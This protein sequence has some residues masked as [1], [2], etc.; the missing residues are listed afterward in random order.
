MRISTC[1]LSAALALTVL[2]PGCAGPEQK[3]GRGLNNITEFVRMG[4]LRRSMEQTAIF[5]SPEVGYTRGFVEG[6]NRSIARTAI[7]AFEIVTFPIPRYG[8][9]FT[10]YLSPNPVFP[11]SYRPGLIADPTF[12]PDAYVGFSGGEVAPFVP[13]SRFRIFDN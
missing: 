5:E 10:N 3:F 1:L 2:G 13:G 9:H 11:D 12:Q 7:G 8:P 6:L 4:E